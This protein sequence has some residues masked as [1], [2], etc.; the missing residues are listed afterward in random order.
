MIS[1]HDFFRKDSTEQQYFPGMTKDFLCLCRYHDPNRIVSSPVTW[2]WHSTI[3]INYITE[4]VLILRTSDNEYHL[5]H[6]DAVFVNSDALH[7]TRWECNKA[8]KFL[9]LI[10]P[11]EFLSGVYGNIYEQ[12]YLRPVIECRNFQSY[13]TQNRTE[14][15]VMMTVSL[16]KIFHL[17]SDEPFGYEFEVRSELCRFWCSLLKAT[18]DMRSRTEN[19]IHAGSRKI[20]PMIEYI[21]EHFAE[22]IFVEQIADAGNMSTRECARCFKK[23]IKMS[24]IDYLNSYR[25]RIAANSLIHDEA[26]IEDIALSCGFNS[27]NYFSKVFRREFGSSPGSY[28]KK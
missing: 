13:A 9:S 14:D 21:Q 3:E 28:R 25:T 11:A 4:G 20:R 5:V 1:N 8:G 10:F 12:K 23:Y 22:K 17:F 7:T 19:R 15:D 24:P 27:V 18:E 26:S 2:H 6:G 16:L